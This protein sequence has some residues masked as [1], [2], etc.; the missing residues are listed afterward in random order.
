MSP[1][2]YCQL[3]T[4]NTVAQTGFMFPQGTATPCV[5]GQADYMTPL[6]EKDY[7]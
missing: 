1:R 4:P 6:A 5:Y 2:V 3:L 7:Q